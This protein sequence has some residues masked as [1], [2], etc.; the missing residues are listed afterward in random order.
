MD[1]NQRIELIKKNTAEVITEEEL[2][3]LLKLGIPLK[4]YIGF[5]ISGYIHLGTGLMCMGKVKD[6]Q[7]AGVNCSVLLADWHTWIN[8]KLGGDLG[9]IK[10]IAGGYF[11]EGLKAS[12]ECMGGN[13]EKLKFVL[14]SDL[15]HNNDEFWQSLVEIS[16]HTTMGRISRSITIMGRKEGEAVDFAKL[17]YAPMQ[18]ADIFAQGINLTHSGIDQRKAHV[19]AIEVAKKIKIKPLMN[20]G[21]TYKPIAVHHPLLL[22]L[23]QPPIWP[24][25]E[26]K[27]KDV[28]SEMKMSKS[29]PKSAVFIHDSP[30]EIKNKLKSAFCPE[31]EISYNPVLDWTKYLVFRDEKSSLK[32]ERPTKFGG[33]II[34]NSYSELEDAF[35]KGNLHPMDLKN[36]VAEYLIKLLEPA[37]K[38]FNT[39][40]VKKMKEELDNLKITR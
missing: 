4:H 24:I 28:L 39:P 26:D 7:D 1:I 22:G 17:L 38:H 3:N 27:V 35:A 11:K 8:D 20:K 40:R 25:A 36:G 13:P 12:L 2:V 5:E 33:D 16:K 14:G 19:I 37:R 23:Q 6:F 15:Y 30:E 32:I 29:I 9:A 21:E 18:V 34:F 10:K 31:K